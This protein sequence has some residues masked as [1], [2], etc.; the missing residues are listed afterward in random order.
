MKKNL[1]I[2]LSWVLVLYGFLFYACKKQESP[3]DLFPLKVGNEF[4]YKYYKGQLMAGTIGNETWKIVS[5]SSQ[6]GS[7]KYLIERK[8]N[9]ILTVFNNRIVITD[10]ITYLEVTEDKSSMISSLFLSGSNIS[11]KRYQNVNKYVIE[12]QNTGTRDSY[13]KYIFVADSG[14]TSCDYR[15]P[16]NQVIHLNMHLDS[17][18]KIP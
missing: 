4:Y 5:E 16:P 3:Y 14:L 2:S 7:V 1:R 9:A 12:H 8:L 13:W 15:T 6:G 11:F 18:K 10:S 17:L